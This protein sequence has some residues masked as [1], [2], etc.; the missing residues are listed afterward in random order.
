[1]P[2]CKRCDGN[3]AYKAGVIRGR[4]RYKCRD[5]GYFFR[6]GD[7]RTSSQT[8]A[9]QAMCILLYSLTGCTYRTVGLLVEYDPA[10]VYR[11]VKKFKEQLPKFKQYLDIKALT[12]EDLKPFIS[13]NREAS[14]ILKTLITKHTNV[15]SEGVAVNILLYLDQA[16]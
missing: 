6:L 8:D 12:F 11:C 5:C 15:F 7:K 14:E 1:M 10:F 9:K 4:Q 2:V 16:N 13:L 3:S